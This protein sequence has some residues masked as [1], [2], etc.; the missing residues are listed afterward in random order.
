ML[1][2]LDKLSHLDTEGHDQV[3]GGMVRVPVAF[4]SELFYLFD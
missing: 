2:M 1:E 4:L 3:L